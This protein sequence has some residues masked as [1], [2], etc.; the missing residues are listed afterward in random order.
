MSNSKNIT[1]AQL[2]EFAE[3]ADNRLDVLEAGT[4]KGY[5]LTLAANGWTNDSGDANYPYR[6]KLT[7]DGITAASRADAVL[8][9]GSVAVASECG[10]CAVSETA[11]NTVIFKSRT[12][13]T[14]DLTGT[15]YITKTPVSS[16][17]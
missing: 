12:A 11:Q 9:A 13:P 8:D 17:K 3:R 2:R 14:A 1:L 6:Y 4:P 15:L 7:V 5:A 16:G 10:V